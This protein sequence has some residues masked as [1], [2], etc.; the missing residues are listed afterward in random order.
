MY[1]HSSTSQDLGW[2]GSYSNGGVSAVYQ[3]RFLKA[4]VDE[5]SATEAVEL[6]T[7]LLATELRA[8][9]SLVLGDEAA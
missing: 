2:Y 8:A 5:C 4:L 1:R 3:R 9:R 7:R 6:A